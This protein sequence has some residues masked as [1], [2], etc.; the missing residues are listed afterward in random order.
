MDLQL[1]GKTALV[2]GG[3][4][5]IGKAIVKQLASEGVDVVISARNIDTLRATAEEISNESGRQIIP[6][7]A[8]TSNNESVAKMAEEA[9][10][11]LGHIDI[12]VNNAAAVGGSGATEQVDTGLVDVD[13]F[14]ND[15]NGKTLGYLRCAR[16]LAPNMQQRGWGR[17]IN[18]SGL[19][20]RNAG[21]YSGGMRNVSVVYLTKTLSNEL[22][23]HGINVTVVH[24]GQTRTEIWPQRLEI[25]AKAQGK[26]PEEFEKDLISR[27]AIRK[28]VD[29]SDIANVVTFLASPRSLAITGDAVIA[30]GGGGNAVY[31]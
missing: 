10:S 29:A 20:A 22:A 30:G 4:R 27:N 6:V 28:M 13:L 12:L 16:A 17:I 14:L 3:S 26:T 31:Y 21:N 1:E 18:I 9:L 25:M 7:V 2:T 15:Y 5:G 23:P 8:D 19:A 11:A 24:P